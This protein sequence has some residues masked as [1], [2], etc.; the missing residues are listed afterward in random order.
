MLTDAL[1]TFVNNLF[2][3]SF[4]ENKKII[5]I[6]IVFSIFHKSSV[7]NFSKIDCYPLPKS[8]N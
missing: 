5:N 3:E 8:T 1:R 2:K 7:K 6:L 4:Y